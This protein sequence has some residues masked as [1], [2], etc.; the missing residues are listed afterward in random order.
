MPENEN[1]VKSLKIFSFHLFQFFIAAFVGSC[2]K[3]RDQLQCGHHSN[4]FQSTGVVAARKHPN[5]NEFGAAQTLIFEF[6]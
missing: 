6:Y 1:I 4:L 2:N 3:F 5:L